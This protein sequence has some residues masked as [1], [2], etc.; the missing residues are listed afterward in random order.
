MKKW[1]AGHKWR[2]ARRRTCAD[3]DS[4]MKYGER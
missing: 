2:V 3:E 4:D 1:Y